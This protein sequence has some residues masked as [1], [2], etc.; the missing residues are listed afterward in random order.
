MT[1]PCACWLTSTELILSLYQ[2]NSPQIIADAQACLSR[3]QGSPQAWIMIQDLL[4]RPDENVKFFGALT[5]IIKLNKESSALSNEDAIELLVRLVGWYIRSL[6]HSDSHMVLRKLSSAIA[7]YFIHFHHLWPLY[8][9]HI[10]LC[11]ACGQSLNPLETRE[12]NELSSALSSLCPRRLQAAVWVVTCVMEDASRI[13]LSAGNKSLYEAILRN[14]PEAVALVTKCLSSDNTAAALSVES[15]RCVQAWIIF[16]QKTSPGLTHDTLSLR[17]LIEAVILSLSD[18]DTFEASAELLVDILTNCPLL[19]TSEH[20]DNLS[21]QLGALW[22]VERYHRLLRGDFDPESMQFGQLLIAF[23]E[24]RTEAL[25]QTNDEIHNHILSA[26]CGLLT[27]HGYLIMEDKIFV[28]AVEFW[29]TYTEAVADIIHFGSD[30]DVSDARVSGATSHVSKAVFSVWQKIIYPPPEVFQQWDSGDRAG[31]NDARKDVLDLLQS[32]HTVLGPGLIA[33]FADLV[34]SALESSA[35]L[36]LEAATFCLGGL[37]ECGK[38]DGRFDEA[39]TSVFA[40]PLTSILQSRDPDID[41]RARQSCFYLIE[42]YAEYFERNT[43]LLGPVLRLLFEVLSDQSTAA[44]ASRSILLL[45]SSCRHHLHP[46]IDEFLLVYSVKVIENRLD[47]VSNEKVLGAIA[48]IAQAIPNAERRH[49]VCMMILEFVQNDVALAQAVTTSAEAANFRC[50]VL[51]CPRIVADEDPA[52][53]T[54]LRALKCL[55]SVGKG[56]QSP[57]DVTIDIEGN[58]QQDEVIGDALPLIHD[59]LMSI[60]VELQHTFPRSSEVM[61]LVCSVFR[62]PDHDPEL[63]QNGIELASRILSRAPLVVLGLQP[64]EAAEFLLMFTIK[65]LDGREPLPK[66][67]AAEFWTAFVSLK[68]DDG[69]VEPAMRRAMQTL[70]P[71]LAQSL[72]RNIGGNASRSELDKLSEPLKKLVV[73]H[74]M[75]KEWLQLGLNH[76]S[77]PSTQVTSEQK[78][79][80]VRKIIS[81]RGSRATNQVIREFWLTSRGSNFAYAS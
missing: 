13:D 53:H 80:L 38:G 40:S 44:S 73:R 5:V 23:G 77:F 27:V 33:S 52:T 42:Q 22:A 30:D 29:S 49:G 70:G 6:V 26:L 9:R 15:L 43:T 39:L 78:A 51:R 71:I 32:A 8:L 66:G 50:Q 35:W 63:S 75:A 61:E 28:S 58:N 46:Q 76:E 41:L 1:A 59:K 17:P 16:A 68:S 56:Y 37:A 72:A 10:V 64:P 34:L 79:L 69:N 3:F 65:V 81:L 36:P 25:I 19:L 60:I 18:K 74:P 7:T 54:G 57:C 62:Y 31:F 2:P 20:Y 14:V 21:K 48:S 45:C 11:L 55:V 4:Q 24:A 12:L 67:A 47:C